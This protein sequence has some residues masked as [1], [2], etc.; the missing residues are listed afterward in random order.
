MADR[1]MGLYGD[2]LGDNDYMMFGDTSFAEDGGGDINMR[3]NG[4]VFEILPAADDTG[5]I[6]VGDGTTDIDVKIFLGTTDNWAEFDVSAKNFETKNIQLKFHNHDTTNTYA[7]EVKYDYQATTGTAFGIDCTCEIEPG[8]G[9]PAARTAGG[10]RA[11]QGVAR[12]QTG[13]T[14]TAGSDA[15]IYGQFCNLGTINGGSNYPSAGYLLVEDGGTWTSVGVLSVLW[16]DTHLAQAISSG[17]SYFLNI[18]NNGSTTT[19]TSAIHVYAGN[20]ITNLFKI[21]TASGMVSANT[22][23]DAT[24]ANY[25]TIKI[26]LDGTTHYLIAAQTI[27]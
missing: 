3:W 19:W 25:K 4:T 6:N 8:G 21:D 12:F 13:F 16:L 9:T 27:S 7:M 20:G 1:S 23:A 24:F 10:L 17:S 5:A 26:D 18:T 22:V 14:S 11:V 15:G 2:A